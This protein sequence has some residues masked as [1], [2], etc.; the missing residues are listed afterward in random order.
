VE[1]L[2]NLSFLLNLNQSYAERQYSKRRGMCFKGL[3]SFS[4]NTDRKG[5]ESK[6]Q[7]NLYTLT[8]L[9]FQRLI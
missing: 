8:H 7:Y 1:N 4:I 2:Q 9:N 5:G 6:D 3:D